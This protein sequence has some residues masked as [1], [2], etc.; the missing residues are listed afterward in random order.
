MIET[1]KEPELSLLYASR[2]PSSI[3]LAQ[4]EFS[5]RAEKIDAI[6][7]AIGNVSLPIHPAMRERMENLFAKGSPFAGGV[8]RYTPTV[9]MDM[10]RRAFL[11]IIASSGMDVENLNVLV[12]DGGS[13]AMELMILGVSGRP[14]TMERPLLVIEPVYTNYIAFAKRL[15]R[16]VVSVKRSLGTDGS[17]ALPSFQEIESMIKHYRPGAM[18]MIPYDNPTGQMYSQEMVMELARLSVKHD[19]WL[20]S[21]EAYRELFYLHDKDDE[22][23]RRGPVSIWA[24]NERN[25]PGIGG[26]RISIE[27]ASKVWNACG[28]RIGA[29]VTDNEEFHRRAVAEYTANLCS[30]AI[31]QYIFGALA[32]ESHDKL[33]KWYERQ[34]NYYRTII[35][36]LHEKLLNK[37]P[38]IIVSAPDSSIYSVV[39]V[40]NIVDSKFDAE[41]FVMYCARE[42]K[43]N[44]NG[45][46]YT[47]LVA[48]MSGFYGVSGGK[49]NE[50]KT[51]MRIA[52]VETP[53][54]M[55]LVP[56]LFALLLERYMRK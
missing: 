18:L 28:L 40:R 10:T 51:Q 11:N 34:R 24:L 56:E 49:S 22:T 52:Y 23:D 5:R 37:I 15:G 30:N 54:R 19:M 13:Q 16:G 4:I 14:G 42:G 9:G 41:D 43:V 26:R 44:Y 50:W 39:D 21:D 48:P 7:V 12:T 45:K 46:D 6:N 35:E 25:V 29:L 47:L 53:E 3:R 31:G 32:E 27:S 17:F 38:E 8:V 36:R 20:V 55:K 2:E 1:R 33:R